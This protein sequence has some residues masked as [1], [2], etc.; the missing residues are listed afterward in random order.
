MW[1]VGD[2]HGAQRMTKLFN[3]NDIQVFPTMEEM[4]KNFSILVQ[5]SKNKRTVI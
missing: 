2:V 4:I 3:K 5:E 1:M